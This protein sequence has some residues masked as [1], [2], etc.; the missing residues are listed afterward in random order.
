[1]KRSFW[2]ILGI[3]ACYC[4]QTSVLSQPSEKKID[5]KTVLSTLTR[6]HPRLMLPKERLA[7]LKEVMRRDPFLKK[8]A[9]EIVA[10]ADTFM[11]KPPLKY[12]KIGPRLLHVSRECLKRVYGLGLAWRLTG[13]ERYAQKTLETVLSVCD[14]ND[15]NPSHFLDTAEMSHAVG[16]G[17]DWLFEYMD[18]KMRER[19][20]TRLIEL[21]LKPGVKAYDGGGS[22]G[23]PAWWVQTEYNWNQVCNAGMIIGALAVAESHPEYARTILP[24]AIDSMHKAIDSYNPDGAWPEGPGYWDYATRYTVYGI[25]ALQSAL[26]TEFGLTKSEGLAQSGYFPLMTAGPTG[27][28]FNFA[29]TVENGRRPLIPSLFWLANQFNAPAYAAAEREFLLNQK[30]LPEH[31]IWYVQP[32]PG[33]V[34]FMPLDKYFKGPVEVATLRSAWNDKNALFVSVK[35]GFNQVNHGHLDLGSFELDALG[36]R[37]ARDLGSD[38]YN[39]PGYWDKAPK[40]KRWDYYRLNSLSH[41]VPLLDNLNQDPLGKAS[42]VKFRSDPSGGFALVDM[43]SAYREKARR[44]MRGVSMVQDR[45]AVLVQDEFDL[46]KSSEVAWGM[47][48]DARIETDGAT[49]LLSRGQNKL[50][51]RILS[52]VGSFFSAESAERRPP[53]KTNKGVNRL[54]IRLKPQKENVTVAV[55]LEPLSTTEISRKSDEERRLIPL[56]DW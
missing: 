49:A 10:Q 21:G 23:K 39:L 34:P 3:V 36:Q 40:G 55:Y 13:D 6:S 27:L 26:G 16:V 20:R 41:N 45:K 17:Y 51:A 9:D 24:A 28:L 42:I 33:P 12:E 44:V 47:T 11:K 5:N 52:P 19:V 8:M 35:A 30:A 48:T 32:P 46:A 37:W 38:D 50:Q 29:D 7:E 25:A 15:W 2:I 53:E 56:K 54:M 18:D 43:T 22:K 31:F 14:F 4:F 1:M